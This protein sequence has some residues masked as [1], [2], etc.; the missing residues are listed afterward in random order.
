MVCTSVVG[1]TTTYYIYKAITRPA[2]VP[3]GAAVSFSVEVN[4]AALTGATISGLNAYIQSDSGTLVN[5]FACGNTDGGINGTGT[6]VFRTPNF[7]IPAANTSLTVGV[8]IALSAAA[9]SCTL[10]VGR[11]EL[12]VV[13]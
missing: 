4:I 9:G 13:S 1:N 10:Q 6:F 12:R 3:I 8:V 5:A 7:T 11:S 2:S